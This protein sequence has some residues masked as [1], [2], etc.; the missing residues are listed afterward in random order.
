[1]RK[2][3]KRKG[4]SRAGGRKGTVAETQNDEAMMAES[5]ES[6]LHQEEIVEE[7]EKQNGEEAKADKDGGETHEEEEVP[8]KPD[9][10]MQDDDQVKDATPSHSQ[11]HNDDKAEKVNEDKKKNPAR[12]GGKRKR[13]TN[14]E[15]EINDGKEPALRAKKSRATKPQEEPEYFEEKRNLQDLWKAAFPVG[16]EFENVDAVYEF[17]WNFKHLEEAL[18]EGGMLYGKKVYVFG[19]AEPMWTSDKMVHVPTIIVIESPFP[20][21][22]KV[23]ITSIQRVAE[24]VPMQKKWVPYIPYEKRDRQVDRMNSQIFSLVCTQRRSA[25][26]HMKE[27]RVKKFEYCIP[28]F[29]DPFKEDELE[30]STVVDILFPSEPPVVCEFDWEVH[31]L[32]EFVDE[33]ALEEG[34]SAEQ[35]K[36]FNEFVKNRVRAAKRGIREAKDARMKAIAEMTEETKQAFQNMKFYKFYPQTS[37]CLYRHNQ[38]AFH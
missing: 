27:D 25:L 30:E 4:G 7:K 28:Y 9:S 33:V 14:K 23:A 6:H 34:L 38:V 22:E 29:Y 13:T 10:L 16:T 19:I 20:P 18:E 37:P 8:V 5:L 11:Q 36:E 26:R 24:I 1:M 12:R 17:N 31:R 35:K 32:E 2:V 21:S 3:A 15:T